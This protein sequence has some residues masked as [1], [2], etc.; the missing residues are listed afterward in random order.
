MT[1][2]RAFEP[3]II[4]VVGESGSGKTTLAK[5][6][7]RLVH[8]TSGSA[9]VYGKLIVGKGDKPSNV[10]FFNMVQ[11]IFQNPFEA[12]SSH[13][14]VEKLP[15]DT[16]VNVAQLQKTEVVAAMAEALRLVG[17]DYQDVRGKYPNQFSANGCRLHALILRPKLSLPTNRSV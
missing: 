5:V 3:V 11:P 14:A 6:I 8:P 2:E 7:L 16:A 12:F 10:E 15:C 13:R 4:S 1:I 9:I 17:L